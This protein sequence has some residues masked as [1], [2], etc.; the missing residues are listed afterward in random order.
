MVDAAFVE[1]LMPNTT[2]ARDGL[3]TNEWIQRI[4]RTQDKHDDRLTKLEIIIARWAVVGAAGT[5]ILTA[6][7]TAAVHYAM[8]I[9]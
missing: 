7:L 5:S 3:S 9:H 6:L 8:G 4:E 2:R 1:E